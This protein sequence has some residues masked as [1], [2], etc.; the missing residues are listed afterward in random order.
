MSCLALVAP[1]HMDDPV[2]V[3]AVEIT[4]L[5]DHLKLEPET[6][7]DS[8]LL[9]LLR[10]PVDT[11]RQLLKV[12]IPVSKT[13][14]VI[15]SCAEPAVVED[16]EFNADF[17]GLPRHREQLLLC[18]IEVSPLPVIEQDRALLISPLTA[19][20]SRSVQ[21]VEDLAH[22]VHALVGVDHDNF[23][24]DKRLTFLKFPGKILRMNSH[25]DPRHVERGHF[26]LGEEVSAV[27]ER[28]SVD[29]PR[30]LSRFFS[31]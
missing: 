15:I 6:E 23:R 9:H 5:I 13:A 28:E 18:E 26:D 11:G 2:R 25:R 14:V 31:L 12:A 4:V 16:K 7:L 10:Q 8:D 27:D 17:F 29:F 22:P 24:R 30:L 1:G 19:G 21:P 20:E 3:R